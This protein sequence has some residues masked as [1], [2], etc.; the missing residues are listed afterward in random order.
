MES[1]ITLSGVA[2]ARSESERCDFCMGRGVGQTS[3]A[4]HQYVQSM[5][6]ILR[7]APPVKG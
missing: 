3:L 1:A 5:A 7:R 4:M 6:P 2:V